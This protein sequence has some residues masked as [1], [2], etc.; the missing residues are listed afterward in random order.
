MTERHF[1]I[2]ADC[3]RG[4]STYEVVDDGNEA[5]ARA[6][7]IKEEANAYAVKV[8]RVEFDDAT[9]NF[10][11]KETLFIGKKLPDP[12]K[13]GEVDGGRN[14]RAA[15]E[16]YRTSSRQMIRRVLGKWLDSLSI[17]PT[18]LLHHV[19][20]MNRLDNAGT[21]MQGAVQQVARMQVR[22]TGQDVQARQ[23][24]LYDLGDK[25]YRDMVLRWRNNPPPKFEN[26]D[27]DTLAKKLAGE[28]EAELLFLCAISDWLLP[29][30]S[31]SEKMFAVLDIMAKSSYPAT[32]DYLDIL[33]SD[34]VD[35]PVF[36]RSIIGEDVELGRAT[37][38]AIHLLTGEGGEEFA[39][40][41]EPFLKHI[42]AGKLNRCRSTLLRKI[43]LTLTSHH[44]FVDGTPLAEAEMNRKLHKLLASDDG[45]IGGI[46]MREAFH[47]RSERLVTPTAVSRLLQ[48]CD[49]TDERVAMLLRLSN[50]IYGE[51]NIRRLGE[52]LL[53]I[54]GQSSYIS[55]WKAKEE[56]ATKRMRDLV[57]LQ[58]CVFNSGLNRRQ[59]ELGGACVDEVCLEVLKEGRVLQRVAA[60]A[61]NPVAAG[62]ALL[63]LYST[64]IFTKGRA[65]DA[66]RDFIIDVL[67]SHDFMKSLLAPNKNTDEKKETLVELS[68]LLQQSDLPETP[69]S[70]ALQAAIN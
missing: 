45:F 5:E 70:A 68:H 3:G 9:G 69:L 21:T 14:C 31:I 12:P 44:S 37:I 60:S 11:E 53:A 4:W 48:G 58:T 39:P 26:E 43:A 2:L 61:G 63:R 66:A 28:P 49:E 59:R 20:H 34:F 38:S 33:F 1:E 65:A 57:E 22:L 24:E 67:R 10:K 51:A 27:A 54:V 25:I 41:F 23:K 19:E 46:D 42:A 17:T 16:Y 30:K 40:A 6:Q 55:E 15:N 52:Y 36:L 50:G 56:P 29:L 7:E 47:T 35:N 62:M 64:G 8:I 18:E 32:I 13:G